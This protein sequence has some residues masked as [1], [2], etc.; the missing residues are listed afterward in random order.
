MS[1]AQAKNKL[2]EIEARYDELLRQMNDPEIS[3]DYQRYTLAAK[4]K[5]EIEDVATAYKAY[6]STLEDIPVAEEMLGMAD[7]D[8]R[9][10][11]QEEL[12]NAKRKADELELH[13]RLLLMPKDPKD[14]RNVIIEIRPAAGGEEAKLFAFE[15]FRMYT[16]YAE[17]RKWKTDIL[18][19]QETGIGGINEATFEIDGKGAYS[20]LKFEG[21][22]HRVQRVPVTESSGR[23]QT[24]TVTVAVMPEV[25]EVE[26]ELNEA[27]IDEEI[28]HSA[29]AGGQ[30]VQKVATAIRLKH[31]P[32]GLVVT[33]Q[34]ERS[35][36]QNKI[37][38]RAVLRS[39]L[40]DM[41][42]QEAHAEQAGTRRSQVGSGERSEKI[43][44]YHFQDGRVTDHRIGLTIH[45]IPTVMD[46][47]IQAFIDSLITA[48]Q[49]EK[50][51]ASS[52]A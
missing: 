33:C 6:K 48:D 17:R 37:K 47:D 42:V 43:R 49:A 3:G 27:D 44:T 1:L 29:G 8:E 28:Y 24:S 5:T 34:D 25:E 40:Y 50:M 19:L 20:Q 4:G 46:G 39:R 13:I 14:D 22:V 16:R 18:N 21:G 38:A 36:L 31:K 10:Y 52:E 45:N 11:Y 2:D 9:L 26:V 12:E 23:M 15:L 41:H 30:N 35:Q 32:T 51:R 7:G